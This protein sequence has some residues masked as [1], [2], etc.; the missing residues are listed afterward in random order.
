MFPFLAVLMCTMGALI[1]I[2]LVTTRRIRTQAIAQKQ[3][4]TLQATIEIETHEPPKLT[5]VAVMPMLH[6]PPVPEMPVLPRREVEEPLLPEITEE[7]PGPTAAELARLEY[8]ARLAQRDLQEQQLNEQMRARLSALH[9]KYSD[10][11][12]QLTTEQHNWM[13]AQ[14]QTNALL[15]D[16]RQLQGANEQMEQQLKQLAAQNTALQQ[17]KSEQEQQLAQLGKRQ[18]QFVE[19]QKNRQP[20]IALVAHDPLAGTNRKPILIECRADSFHFPSEGISISAADC[21]GFL[22]DD[23]PLRAG[24]EAL[25]EFQKRT[26]TTGNENAEKPYV[27]L[28]VRPGGTTGF[29]VARKLLEGTEAEAGYELVLDEDEMAWPESNPQAAYACRRAV[30]ESLRKQEAAAQFI[31][32][33]R[34]R[35]YTETLTFADERGTFRMAEV[36]RMRNVQDP[37]AIANPEWVSPHRRNSPTPDDFGSG[38]RLYSPKSQSNTGS[39]ETQRNA[40]A[41]ENPFAGSQ[42]ANPFGQQQGRAGSIVPPAVDQP[43]RPGEGVGGFRDESSTALAPNGATSPAGSSQRGSATTG[44][45]TAGMG[46]PEA[47]SALPD[48]GQSSAGGGQRNGEPRPRFPSARSGAIGVEREVAIDVWNDRIASGD[49]VAQQTV[50]LANVRDSLDL[51]RQMA[52]LVEIEVRSWGA[53]PSGFV[54]RPQ[55]TFVVHPGGNAQLGHVAEVVHSWGLK[56]STEHVLE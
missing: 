26:Q 54:W 3:Q 39:A 31:P 18:Q 41:A 56:S 30:E 13:T 29:Y 23:N 25:V 11:A 51:Q 14:S 24:V 28:V 47:L 20:R 42:Q 53:A 52:A 16:V 9:D 27:L 1:L 44:S 4:E 36:D 6:V 19:D 35:R 5:P 12:Q 48:F 34:D 8:E 49:G 43:F 46:T 38:R 37:Y 2:L 32:G 7:P 55:V 10:R 50:S 40:N 17:K 22:P 15:A 45:P 21:N 33:G